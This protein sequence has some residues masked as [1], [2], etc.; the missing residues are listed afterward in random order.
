MRDLVQ[1]AAQYLLQLVGAKGYKLDH[2]AGR[3]V[4]DSRPFQIFEGSN[5][6]LYQQITESVIKL[7]RKMPT[8]NLYDFLKENAYTEKAVD[9]FKD[10]FN[11]SIDYNLAQRKMVELGRA[12]SRLVSMNITID[13]GQ[14][15]FNEEMISH[16]LAVLQ[17]EIR[18]IMTGYSLNN[19]ADFVYDRQ[20]GSN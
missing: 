19:N 20:A 14:K 8:A 13:L 11:F 9:Y 15:G 12:I 6:I 17:K 10:I 2:I 5:D 3:S 16:S 4:I 18:M 7:I 1:Q